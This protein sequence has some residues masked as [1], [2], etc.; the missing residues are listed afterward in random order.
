MMSDVSLVF[1]CIP[2]VFK[3]VRLKDLPIVVTADVIYAQ[4]CIVIYVL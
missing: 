2:H 1:Y 3:V 4:V